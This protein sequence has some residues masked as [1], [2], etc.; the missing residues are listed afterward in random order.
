MPNFAMQAK[1]EVFFGVRIR[2]P[3][4]MNWAETI[5]HLESE[6]YLAQVGHQQDDKAPLP[7]PRAPKVMKHDKTRDDFFVTRQ[8]DNDDSEVDYIEYD[9]GEEEFPAAAKK[10]LDKIFAKEDQEEPEPHGLTF[11]LRASSGED[12][13]FDDDDWHQNTAL[14]LIHSS[15]CSAT[16]RKESVHR[17]GSVWTNL[18]WGL[19]SQ[20][21]PTEAP[22]GAMQKIQ[23][24]VETL[25]LEIQS[26]EG[27]QE[28]AGPGWYFCSTCS[29]SQD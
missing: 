13:E 28:Q 1:A 25:G 29:S 21:I 17:D 4:C 3:K 10:V 14:F 5:S 22:K 16:G 20:R 19:Q 8:E 11:R 26:D 27:D 2:I 24:V 15:S 9:G 18:P 12:G 7:Q 23:H 6:E